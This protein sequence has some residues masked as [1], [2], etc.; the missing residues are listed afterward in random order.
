MDFYFEDDLSDMRVSGMS[1]LLDEIDALVNMDPEEGA[2][3]NLDNEDDTLLD[4]DAHPGR[5]EDPRGS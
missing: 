1:D 4:E 2:L 5:V 3:G